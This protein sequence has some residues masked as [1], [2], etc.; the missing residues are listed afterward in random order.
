MINITN[1]IQHI[2]TDQCFPQTHYHTDQTQDNIVSSGRGDAKGV[3]GD[4]DSTARLR[5]AGG[6]ARSTEPL[7]TH[8][9]RP[10]DIPE[11]D[12]LQSD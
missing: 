10:K 7:Q 12:L 8:S 5:L 11:S 4:I 9:D 2:T 3:G 6:T 1:Q